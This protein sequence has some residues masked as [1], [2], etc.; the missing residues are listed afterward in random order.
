MMD[1]LVL[2][3]ICCRVGSSFA[4]RYGVLCKSCMDVTSFAELL[5]LW[6]SFNRLLCFRIWSVTTSTLLT[7]ATSSIKYVIGFYV[8]SKAVSN[9]ITFHVVCP[10]REFRTCIPMAKLFTYWTM[11][12]TSDKHSA[13]RVS[14]K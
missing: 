13:R 11:A 10:L 1:D 9:I 7:S 4:V 2:I 8:R 14:C 12:V 5:S 6:P 3:P